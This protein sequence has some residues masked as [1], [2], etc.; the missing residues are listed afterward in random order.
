MTAS[1][2]ERLS[3]CLAFDRSRLSRRLRDVEHLLRHGRHGAAAQGKL[4]ALTREIEKASAEAASRAARL[5]RPTFPPDLPI[6][7]RKDEIAALIRDHQVVVVCGETGSGKSTQLPKICLELGRGTRGFIG[8]TQPR[9]IAA[10]AVAERLSE[11]LGSAPGD[12]V[13][14]KVRFTDHTRPSCF[15]KVMTDGVLLAETQGDRL[16]ERYDTLIIDEAHERSLNID[17]LLGYVRTILPQRPDLKVIITSATIDPQRFAEHFGLAGRVPDGAAPGDAPPASI[18]APVIEVSGRTYPVELRYRPLRSDEPDAE[19]RSLSS[20]VIDAVDEL[21]REATGD[22]PGDTLVF[23]PGEREIREVAE[24]LEKHHAHREGSG[25]SRHGLEVLPLYARL[26]AEDQHRVFRRR[27][28]VRR[29]VLATNVAETSLTVP[30]IRSVVDSGLARISRYSSRSRVQALPIEK[31]SRASAAQRSGRCGRIGPGVCIRLYGEDDF[32]EREEFTPPE[33]LRTNLASV[34]LQMKALRLGEI[35]RFPFVEAPNPRA[36]QEG[37]E[38]LTEL[39][40]IDDKGRLTPIGTAM[41]RLPIDPRLARM[42]LAA[43]RE[44]CVPEVLV[45]AAALSVQDPRERPLDQRDAADKAHARWVNAHIP[46]EPEP[47]GAPI[48]GVARRRE[49]AE[50]KSGSD[51]MAIV[52]LWGEVQRRKGELSSSKFRKWCRENFLGYVRVREWMDVHAQLHR[53]V[54][55]MGVSHEARNHPDGK[56]ADEGHVHRALLTGLLVNVGRFDE[57]TREYAGT[58]GAKFSVF[59][60]SAMFS[61]KAKWVMAAERVRTTR[62][63]SRTVARIRPEWIEELAPTLIKRSYADTTW[64]ERTG[65]AH[66]FETVFL[67][68]LEV[69][70]RR[71]ANLAQ[72]D[73]PAARAAFIHH[74]LLDGKYHHQGAFF[75]HNQRVLAEAHRLE[76]K[77]RRRDLTADLTRRFEFYDKRLPEKATSGGAFE[78][79]RTFAEQREPDLLKMHLRDLLRPGATLPDPAETPET[80]TL[81]GGRFPLS[82]RFDPGDHDDGVTVTIPLAAL[83]GINPGA[84]EWVVPGWVRAKVTELLRTLPKEVR[85]ALGPAPEVVDEFVRGSADRSRSML[86]RLAAFV[87]SRAGTVVSP[88]QFH[89]ADLPLHLTMRVLVTDAR[90]RPIASG[91]DLSALREQLKSQ[92]AGSLASLRGTEFNRTGMTDWECGD[93]PERVEV[94]AGGARVPAYPALTEEG[95][96]VGMRLCD[97]ADA[98]AASH[99]AGLRRLFALRVKGEIRAALDHAPGIDGLVKVWGPLGTTAELFDTLALM[100]ADRVFLSDRPDVRTFEAFKARVDA[101]FGSLVSVSLE[102][103]ALA[104]AT[105]GALHRVSLRLD[106]MKTTRG[107]E[108]WAPA[109][110]GVTNQLSHLCPRGFLLSTPSERLAHL[111]R[112]LRAIESRLEKIQQGKISQDQQRAAELRPFLRRWLD[113]LDR[114]GARLDGVALEAYRWMLEEFRV[115]LFAQELRPQGPALASP[116]KLEEAWERVVGAGAAGAGGIAGVGR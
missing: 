37:Y 32:I 18:P 2:R 26:S 23:L 91:R 56:V 103:V 60:G 77:A 6:V 80:I 65:T 20:A 104:A 98:A 46:K 4:E 84:L 52:N 30:G 89:G 88:A 58:H 106:V 113:T 71:R 42:I 11:E 44:K 93:I 102:V 27:A 24:E 14:Y 74:A 5:P 10:R 100:V 36:I 87:S 33:I 73:P 35:E 111:P 61:A 7:Q 28:G 68:G 51:F 12:L 55:E 101:G 34:I 115:H 109:L 69:I 1:I 66:V 92:I 114:P 53:L 57:S 41:A 31:V 81:A 29:I 116:R 59:P 108:A 72:V 110:E 39:G 8:H 83:N 67:F 75:A 86:E 105:I 9:R 90:G 107:T 3:G 22:E 62:V 17:F 48:P 15:V 63:Y 54:T 19:D 78:R 94:D 49:D 99:Q 76:A 50:E 96:T 16:L 97:A 85:K 21:G 82:Y 43:E 45:I 112:Y 64:N 70:P 25:G 47:E 79:W 95:R 13:G 38:T 40:A